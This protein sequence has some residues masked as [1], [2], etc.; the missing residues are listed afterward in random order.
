MKTVMMNSRRQQAFDKVATDPDLDAEVDILMIMGLDARQ[1]IMV[2]HANNG[3]DV[4]LANTQEETQNPVV[5][6]VAEPKDVP[7]Q[8]HQQQE[9]LGGSK[10]KGVN[11]TALQSPQDSDKENDDG[12]TALVPPKEIQ[13]PRRV[14]SIQ[15]GEKRA[16][17]P[18]R[19]R[20]HQVKHRVAGPRR[21]E[22]L[23]VYDPA[24]ITENSDLNAARWLLGW[25]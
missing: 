23:E 22:R 11:E 25:P 15:K 16:P 7:E 21:R 19:S 10:G 12:A 2:L 6:G 24:S 5:Q 4:G 3:G 8:T 18:K 20:K 17:V 9:D 1:A 13:Q 14:T